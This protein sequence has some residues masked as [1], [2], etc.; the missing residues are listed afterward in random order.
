[1]ETK[2]YKISQV[3]ARAKE[4]PVIF[5]AKQL[6]ETKKAIYLYGHGTAEVRKT[7][8]CMKC[9]RDLEHPVSVELGI[10]PICGEHYWSWDAVGGFTKENIENLSKKMEEII[11][12][13][14]F[15]KS[16]VKETFEANETEVKVPAKHKMLKNKD[17]N[18]KKASRSAYKVKF[19]KSGK[20]A[21]K[22]VFPFNY[23]DLDR[24]KTLPGR[25]FNAN[26]KYWTAP[27]SVEAVEKL[28]EWGFYLDQ[29][30]LE[31]LEK[32]K[33]NVDDVK[34]IVVPGIDKYLYEYQR[35][36]ISFA[37]IKDGRALIADDMGLG[38]TVQAIGYLALH[39][40][41]VPVIV[42]VPASLKLNWKKELNQ[43]LNNPNVQILNG[44]K[45]N[46]PI[47]GDV[48]IINYDILPYWVDELK[49]IK[50]QVLITDECHYYKNNKAKRTKAVKKLGKNIPHVIA[51]SGTPIEN[52]PK[53]IF[54][55]VNL[56]DNTVFPD[57]WN[58]AHRYCDA[59]HDGF[60]WDF[61][62]ASN[63]EELHEKLTN[64]IMIRRRKNEVLTELP[65]KI[66]DHIPMELDNRK[67]YDKAESDFTEYAT[68]QVEEELKKKIQEEF[69]NMANAIKIDDKKVKE[70]KAERAN[71]VN[72]LTEIEGLKQLAI[73][74]KMNACIKWIN[75]FL[76]VEN[77]LVVFA[78]HK[79]TINVL[80]EEF[81]NIAVKIDGSVSQEQ[82]H[83]AV[84]KFQNNPKT[85]LFIG[86]I[87]AAGVGLTLTAASSVA[88][89][90]LPWTPG[91]LTQAEDRLHRI[92]QKDTVNVYY[93]LANDTIEQKIASI[94]DQKRQ[95]LDQVLDGKETDQNNLITELIEQ[96][97]K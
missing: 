90:E 55:A 93:L 71:R 45:P 24:V 37:E 64:T 33:L 15:P 73:K 27:L 95:T 76:G 92:G 52:R 81:G 88:F 74:G 19:Q 75:E 8:M 44:T 56:I 66:Y 31:F 89:L 60:G 36:G 46:V 21:I 49:K 29:K 54:N 4:Y 6:A 3:F 51:L 38:K 94:L 32:S 68:N 20:P 53:E 25:K 11:V 5:A 58:F 47:T 13:G 62:G 67:E 17:E 72:V 80:M 9:G 26:E 57:F 41:K 87:K 18:S 14:W 97:K 91:A 40:E 2:L 63:T 84:N 70:L 35:K 96:Y 30:L 50:P 43:W 28:K 78:T 39:P 65:D 22:I 48:L 1:M 79:E 7:G 59:K 77:K 69:G 16:I 61:D 86:N 42:V 23:N 83:E 10:G 85:R 12:D 82:R 34:E